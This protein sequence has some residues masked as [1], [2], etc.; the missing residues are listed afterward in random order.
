MDQDKIRMEILWQIA[1]YPGIRKRPLVEQVR[2]SLSL[3]SDSPIESFL[4]WFTENGIVSSVSV[5]DPSRPYQGCIYISPTFKAFMYAYELFCKRG[6]QKEFMKTIYFIEY[7]SSR[8]FI[9]KVLLGIFKSGMLELN[10]FV[11]GNGLKGVIESVRTPPRIVTA[12]EWKRR[13]ENKP[14]SMADDVYRKYLEEID[15]A[16]EQSRKKFMRDLKALESGDLSSPFTGEYRQ[17]IA[18]LKGNDLDALSVAL[19]KRLNRQNSTEFGSCSEFLADYMMPEYEQSNLSLMLSLS[20]SAV[21]YMLKPKYPSTTLL[22]TVAGLMLNEAVPPSFFAPVTKYEV[23]SLY[24]GDVSPLYSVIRSYFIA[25]MMNDRLI[26]GKGAEGVI[27]EAFSK[28]RIVKVT[29]V[30]TI[31]MQD[32]KP[33]GEP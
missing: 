30:P 24:S 27:N 11:E 20:P 1:S 16:E 26:I 28:K 17:L 22:S 32:K 9:T 33:K 10:A 2:N 18:E 21:E 14:A 12:E 23:E 6:C 5:R 25:D 19:A 31:T 7:T 15:A 8:D 13:M 4:K 29:T 3:S